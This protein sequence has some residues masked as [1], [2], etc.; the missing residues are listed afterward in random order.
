MVTQ[1]IHQMWVFSFSTLLMRRWIMCLYS[2]WDLSQTDQQNNKIF[3][4]NINEE[5]NFSVN[6]ENCLFSNVV[7]HIQTSSIFQTYLSVP[8]VCIYPARSMLRSKSLDWANLMSWNL[9]RYR[10]P[11]QVIKVSQSTTLLCYFM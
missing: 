10:E 6:S 7:S 9:I 4:M 5:S 1:Q 11:S 3:G 2:S 8:P